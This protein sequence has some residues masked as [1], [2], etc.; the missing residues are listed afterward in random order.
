[1]NVYRIYVS[2]TLVF[3]SVLREIAESIAADFVSEFG[4]AVTRNW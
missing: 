2:G 1:M 4:D 3:Q